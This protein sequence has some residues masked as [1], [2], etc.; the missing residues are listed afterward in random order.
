MAS[1]VNPFARLGQLL[2]EEKTEIS[3]IYFYAI[4]SGLIQ[5]SLPLGIQSIIGF[6]LGGAL[7]TSLVILITFVVVGVACNG[8]LQIGQMKVIERI[9]QKIFVRYS[10]AFTT[11]I[12][13]LDLP[14]TDG[15]YLPELVNRFF[16]IPVLQKS[17]SKL[18][19]DFPIAITQIL[20]GLLMLS[21]YHP[22]FIAFGILLLL[23][24]AAIFFI[25]GN[26]GFETSLEKSTHKYAVAAWLEEMARVVKQFKFSAHTGLHSRRSDEKIVSYLQARTSHFRILLLQYKVLIVFKVLITAAMLV[27]GCLLLLDQQINIGQFV[28]AEIIIILVINSVEKLIV[29]LDSV[30]SALTSVEKINKLMDKPVEAEGTLSLTTGAVKVE[31]RNVSFAYSDGKKILNNL[32]FVINPGDKVLFNGPNGSGKSTVL[33]LLTGGYTAFKGSILIND[34]P[35]GNYNL[36]SLRSQTGILL[37]QQDVFLGTIWENLT[38]GAA[39]VDNEYLHYLCRETGLHNFIALQKTGF[40]TP[41]QPMGKQLPGGVIKRILLVRLLL[42]KPKL[43]LIEEPYNSIEGEDKKRVQDLLLQPKDTTVIAVSIDKAFAGLYNNI[44]SLDEKTN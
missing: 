44:I 32:S 35:I 10:F 25:T 26:R 1:T 15:W 21:F 5:L 27:V 22:A 37:H 4:L 20:L 40:D 39:D 13:K 6:V 19:L 7:S 28:A 38:M 42:Q 23:L 17:I 43:L 30:Y 8:L 18:L 41:L 24:L 34:V 12:P 33:K 31:F 29:N 11:H 36:Q 16:D 2:R 14:Q 9:Q 3:S